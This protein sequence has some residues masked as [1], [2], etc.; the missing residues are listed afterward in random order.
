MFFLLLVGRKLINFLIEFFMWFNHVHI[1]QVPCKMPTW[2][3]YL[4]SFYFVTHS[5][6]LVYSILKVPL[7][8]GR[9]TYWLLES[10]IILALKD[11]STREDVL[12][13]ALRVEYQH[14][15]FLV[16]I[17]SGHITGF[18]TRFLKFASQAFPRILF[19]P[20]ILEGKP[21]K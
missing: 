5:W 13:Y 12:T 17:V 4:F 1:F 14:G 16:I 3:L 11:I 21:C 6:L 15:I 9:R 8:S 19:Y 20:I 10:N 2:Y 7:F 18:F